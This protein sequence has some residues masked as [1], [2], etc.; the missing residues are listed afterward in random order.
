MPDFTFTSP[1][2]KKYTVSGPPG[3]TPEQAYGVLQKQLAA[4]PPAPA[5][6]NPAFPRTKGD[7]PTPEALSADALEPAP[8]S[9]GLGEMATGAGEAALSAATAPFGA[10]QGLGAALGHRAIGDEDFGHAY[11]RVS[12]ANTYSPKTETGKDYVNKVGNVLGELPP[13]LPEAGAIGAAMRGAA[14]AVGRAAGAAKGAV[15]AGLPSVDPAVAKLAQKAQELGIPLRPDMLTDNQLVRL[16]GDALE[17]VPLS[18]GKAGERATAFNKAVMKQIGADPE[19][20]KLTPEIF[21]K[22]IDGS[23]KAIGE[24]AGRYNL[25]MNTALE[26]QILTHIEEAQKFAT[27]DVD[28][29]LNGHVNDI[30]EKVKPDGTIE[31]KA[32]REWNTRITA[33][34]RSTQNGDLRNTLTGLQRDVMRAMQRSISAKDLPRFEEARRQYANAIALEPVVAKSATGDIS[35]SAVFTQMTNSK[36]KQRLMARGQGG[37]MADVARIGK[38][39]VQEPS[40]SVTAERE[41]AYKT[42]GAAGAITAGSLN[43]GAAAAAGGVYGLANVYNRLAPSLAKSLGGRKMLDRMQERMKEQPG[44]AP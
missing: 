28:K 11:D 4:G 30:L 18:G 2:G 43:P 8:E 22:A 40:S 23:G 17:K 33:Q 39:F 5:E 41:M 6:P 25:P 16:A 27:P 3:A 19:A 21:S 10:A 26:D 24:I 42:L 35:P 14:P 15:K 34:I 12:E 20:P 44:T 32:W 31:G 36:G 9:P 29:V 37:E 1:E 7:I 38:R 13:I